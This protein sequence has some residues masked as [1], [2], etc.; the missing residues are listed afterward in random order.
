MVTSDGQTSAHTAIVIILS[1]VPDFF[2]FPLG[3][4]SYLLADVIFPPTP[5]PLLFFWDASIYSDLYPLDLV[6]LTSYLD[7]RY[8]Y[9]LRTNE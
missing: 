9:L 6:C 1:L 8:S 4:V 5:S 7:L 2:P 3:F